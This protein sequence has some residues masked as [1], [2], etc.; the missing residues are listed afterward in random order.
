MTYHDTLGT[1]FTTNAHQALE[2]FFF[3]ASGRLQLS[4]F[5][6]WPR[7]RRLRLP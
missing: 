1:A 4:T 6:T 2:T 3:F 5:K 7:T